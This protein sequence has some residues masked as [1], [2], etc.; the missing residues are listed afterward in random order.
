[1]DLSK[2][3]NKNV[4]ENQTRKRTVFELTAGDFMYMKGPATKTLLSKI[5]KNFP[6]CFDYFYN[7][8]LI[9]E[10][11]DV[12]DKTTEGVLN[13]E[14]EQGIDIAKDFCS[15]EFNKK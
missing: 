3:F 7:F 14:A 9:D 10:N 15:F 11:S 1:M 4:R 13:A 6:E 12:Y 2:V 8:F 5:G